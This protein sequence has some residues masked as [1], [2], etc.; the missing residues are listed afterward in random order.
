MTETLRDAEG[1]RIEYRPLTDLR[2]N[3]KNPKAHNDETITASIHRFGYIEP[4]VLDGRTGYIVSGHGRT[5]ALRRAEAK[6]GTPPE[7]VTLDAEGRWL[8]PVVTGWDSADDFEATAALIALNRTTELGGWVDEALLAALEVLSEHDDGLT[9]VGYSEDDMIALRAAL[10]DPDE[11]GGAGGPDYTRR[12]DI[13]QYEPKMDAPPK[14]SELTDTSRTMELL[15]AIQAT[16]DLHDE[17]RAFLIAAAA[18]HTRFNYALI[19][20]FYAHADA[21]VQALME[22][23]AL[24][25]IDAADAMQ[26]GYVRLSERMAEILQGDVEDDLGDADA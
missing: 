2:A 3:P 15:H 5:E 12:V 18:R 23:S 17:V 14:P 25:I 11:G 8:A 24:V 10:A 1:R 16:P 21:P 13:P 20:E 19:A 4:V 9:G 26:H 6:G 7:G 22:Q